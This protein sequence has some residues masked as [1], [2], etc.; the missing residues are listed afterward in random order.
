MDVLL[1]S[2]FCK[3]QQCLFCV[4]ISCIEDAM[5]IKLLKIKRNKG[6]CS[7]SEVKLDNQELI[8]YIL[9]N[10]IFPPMLQLV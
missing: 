8:S 5:V 1:Q 6:M 7:F 3:N 2:F 4:N 9:F 10:K